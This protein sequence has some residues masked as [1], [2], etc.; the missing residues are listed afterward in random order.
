MRNT[1]TCFFV[2]SGFFFFLIYLRFFKFSW[3]QADLLRATL[4]YPEGMA[5]KHTVQQKKL[6]LQNAGT[7]PGSSALGRHVTFHDEGKRFA[8]CR[9]HT[10]ISLC[11][12]SW[13]PLQASSWTKDVTA[14]LPFTAAA[15]YCSAAYAAG[16][17]HKCPD[18]LMQRPWKTRV[19][20]Q[21]PTGHGSAPL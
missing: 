19:L 2:D 21:L 7:Q 14:Q 5:G 3:G 8:G 11:L 6:P 1:L 15:S 10:W 20:P 16:S 13:R 4:K 9:H 17:S 12:I 18:C